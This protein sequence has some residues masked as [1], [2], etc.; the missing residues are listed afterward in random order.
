[1]S[2][3]LKKRDPSLPNDFSNSMIGYRLLA[4]PPETPR[5]RERKRS[6]WIILFL[7]S[8]ASRQIVK[9][10]RA[11]TRRPFPNFDLLF[12]HNTPFPSLECYPFLARPRPHQLVGRTIFAIRVV[13]AQAR[14]SCN[15]LSYCPTIGDGRFHA[16]NSFLAS[17]DI[18]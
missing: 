15:C 16:F 18:F 3:K 11:I 4:R 8:Q 6:R 9:V 12:H 17:A 14:I 2:S 5:T 7:S 10:P 1:M 13:L